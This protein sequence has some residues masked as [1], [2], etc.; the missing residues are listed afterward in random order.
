MTMTVR[1]VGAI[2]FV[3]GC[4]LQG[5]SFY[6]LYYNWFYEEASNIGFSLLIITS[7]FIWTEGLALLKI[8]SGLYPKKVLSL[9]ALGF[10]LMLSGFSALIIL[11]NFLLFL[12]FSIS[13]IVAYSGIVFYEISHPEKFK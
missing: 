12:L 2:V 1:M 5:L 7:A 3:V 10:A 9:F 11:E 8:K 4:I 6:L 13:G